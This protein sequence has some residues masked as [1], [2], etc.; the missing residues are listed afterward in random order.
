MVVW[1]TAGVSEPGGEGGAGRGAPT[2][3]PLRGGGAGG[4]MGAGATA[5]VW[6]G[7]R[8]PDPRAGGGGGTAEGEEGGGVWGG[9]RGGGI[10]F[11]DAA[12]SW[13]GGEWEEIMGKAPGGRGDE[14]VRG[15]MYSS[16]S[17]ERNGGGNSRL[18][19]LRGV[20]A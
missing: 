3:Q 11:C 12:D 17:K 18:W 5:A 7:A 6:A 16:M 13:G 8:G 15:P 1:V 10:N 2:W 14:V 4:R 19:I 9:A 20:E